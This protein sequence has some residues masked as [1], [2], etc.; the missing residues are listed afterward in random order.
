MLRCMASAVSFLYRTRRSLFLAITA[1]LAIATLLNAAPTYKRY[2]LVVGNSHYTF[3]PVLPNP[4]NDSRAMRTSLEVLGFHVL[5]KEDITLQELEEAIE[6]MGK[7]SEGT[8]I[9]VF[10]YAGHGIQVKGKN[11]LVPTDAKLQIE[12]DVRY[13]ATSLDFALGHFEDIHARATIVILDA[14]RD[15][16]LPPDK[17]ATIAGGGLAAVGSGG[18]LV[19]F[20]TAANHS[21]DDGHLQ[22]SPYTQAILDHIADP[23]A[24]IEE[25]FKRVRIEVKNTTNNGQTP[26]EYNLNPA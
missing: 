10:Y 4:V 9:A 2:A 7:E 19:E 5:Y 16:P 3:L 8:D 6:L 23:D 22:H 15:N 26:F 21:A 12:T 1:S 11:Y 13:K 24:Q 18:T 14:C 25:V 17:R 20:A